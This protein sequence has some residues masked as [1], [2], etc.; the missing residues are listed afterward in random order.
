M[1]KLTL[2]FIAL[3]GAAVL[4]TGV[5]VVPV[6]AKA[7][8]VSD[9]IEALA[10]LQSDDDFSPEDWIPADYVGFVRIRMDAAGIALSDLNTA[11]VAAAMLQPARVVISQ[12]LGYETFVSLAALDVEDASFATDILPWLRDEVVL[13]YRQLGP[14]LSAAEEDVLMILPS[15]D[16]FGSADAMGRIIQ[17]QD[18][19]DATTYRDVSIYTGDRASFAFMPEAVL[20]GSIDAI[21]AALD[22]RAAEA[23]ALTAQDSYTTV[24]EAQGQNEAAPLTEEIIFA[25]LGGDDVV[26][27]ALSLLLSGNESGEPLL[28]ALGDALRAIRNSEGFERSLLSDTPDAVSVSIAITAPLLSAPVINATAIMHVPNSVAVGLG[29]GSAE[30]TETPASTPATFDPSVLDFIPRSAMMVQSGPDAAGAGYDLLVAL[31]LFSFSGQMLGGFSAAGI[32]A[33]PSPLVD[34]PSA[35]NVQTAVTSFLEALDVVANYS[36]EDDFFA[37]LDGSYAVA[38]LPRPNDPTPMLNTPFDILI[39]AQVDDGAAASAGAIEF[40]ETALDFGTFETETPANGDGDQ[41]FET[42]RVVAGGDPVL[43]IGTVSDGDI[44]V[45][46]TGSALERVLDAERGDN[47][48]VDQQRWH[49]LTEISSETPNL[50]INFNAL[51]NTLAPSPGGEVPPVGVR[52][53]AARVQSIGEG[54]FRLEATITL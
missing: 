46:G 30:A 4:L 24:L 3:I 37:H 23:E 11:M 1:R 47:R 50:Y 38:L 44:M 51:F 15:N 48:L 49:D 45:I 17:A 40:I 5:F 25:Y 42:L 19:G 53:L 29:A 13:A 16:F 36:L 27:P 7:Q 26:M 32:A 2:F 43:Q 9:A 21:H 28:M 8:D 22:V 35:A 12:Q 18:L 52:Q 34:Q 33:T 14:G 41:S 10:D 39:L 20:V 54:L 31:P 6:P